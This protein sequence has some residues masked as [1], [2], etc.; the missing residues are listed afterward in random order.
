MALL[1]LQEKGWAFELEVQNAQGTPVW[2]SGCSSWG[3]FLLFFLVAFLSGITEVPFDNLSPWQHFLAFFLTTD[4]HLRGL[5]LVVAVLQSPIV[6]SS[7]C[8]PVAS[9]SVN[10][11]FDPRPLISNSY[12]N[13]V[14]S[15]PSFLA[16]TL[17]SSYLSVLLPQWT[18]SYQYACSFSN[19]IPCL[20]FLL[21]F[22][23]APNLGSGVTFS[24]IFQS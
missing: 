24:M 5:S 6:P 9:G 21:L 3:H 20:I 4:S 8:S 17:T 16:S 15:Q 22:M 11:W 7:S 13:S 10:S 2:H 18:Y 19:M 14:C 12:R 23:S 1:S